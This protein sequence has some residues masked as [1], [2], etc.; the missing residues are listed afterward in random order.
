M[1]EP[2]SAYDWILFAPKHPGDTQILP[3]VPETEQGQAQLRQ[4]AEDLARRFNSTVFAC[5][6]VAIA[7]PEATP[8]P[9]K[10]VTEW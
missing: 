1:N 10:W 6:V 3:H 5:R 7:A 9:V 8:I 2:K 4:R